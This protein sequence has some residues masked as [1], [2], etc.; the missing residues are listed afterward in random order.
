MGVADHARALLAHDRQ[1]FPDS[2]G[3][4]VQAS[5]ADCP[6]G[7]RL[8]RADRHARL[9]ARIFA[10]T[11]LKA[12][13]LGVHALIREN[14]TATQ[15]VRLRGKWVNV[16]PSS[17]GA[18]KDMS[19]EIGLGSAGREQDLMA[20]QGILEK[21]AELVQL[22]GGLDG[23][24]MSPKN[25]YNALSL[26]VKAAGKKTP[27]LFFSDPDDPQRQQ[28]LAQQP[29]KQDPELAKLEGQLKLQSATAQA[30]AEHQAQAAHADMEL[31]REKTA[32]QM[33]MDATKAEREHELAVMRVQG[34]LR[35]KTETAAAELQLKREL[36]VEELQMKREVALMNAQV[37]HETGMA[38]AQ[39][40]G[41]VS[42]VEVGGEPG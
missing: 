39:S 27:E 20:A 19:I 29:P 24:L 25:A 22:Q 15:K 18:R 36:L 13:Y 7:A 34:E 32:A 12:M 33:Q 42:E 26:F 5:R 3:V 37:A 16:D 11:G 28:A 41:S 8:S 31:Q 2:H 14:A 9:I 38:K 23:P 10:E 4:E 21:Q 1:V 40:S 17:W 6:N 30:N 35:L